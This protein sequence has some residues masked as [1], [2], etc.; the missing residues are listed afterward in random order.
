MLI[1]MLSTLGSSLLLSCVATLG[2]CVKL[3]GSWILGA[4]ELVCCVRLERCRSTAEVAAKVAGVLPEGCWTFGAVMLGVLVLSKEVVLGVDLRAVE[5]LVRCV[6]FV[7]CVAYLYS[8]LAGIGCCRSWLLVWF[9]CWVL[10]CCFR[11]KLLG[12]Q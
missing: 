8:K 6:A 7:Q 9:C 10:E 3:L 11:L 12:R 5:Y 2:Y 1:C 4:V